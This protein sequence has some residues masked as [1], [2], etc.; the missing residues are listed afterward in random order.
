MS[1]ESSRRVPSGIAAA[2]VLGAAGGAVAWLAATGWSHVVTGYVRLDQLTMLT[3]G[4][5]VGAVTLGGDA[6][7]RRQRVGAPI[8]NGVIVGGVSALAVATVVAL[9]SA[10]GDTGFL[11]QR[12]AGWCAVVTVSSAALASVHGSPI[13][14]AHATVGI[15]LLGGIICGLVA[16]LP[17]AAEFWW[18]IAF[19]V[20]GA[21]IAIAVTGPRLWQAVAIVEHA[22]ARN[23]IPG[24]LALR[25]WAIDDGDVVALGTAQLSCNDGHV[26]LHPPA[27]GATVNGLLKTRG[28]YIPVSC[29]IAVGG[30]RYL[31]QVR[32]NPG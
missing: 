3:L 7:R 31:V 9:L 15:G 12:A 21:T 25:E 5:I 24:L 20:A 32:N 6:L 8:I 14:A 10:T 29:V 26:A 27:G 17:G 4:A 13:R 1:T 22:P 19:T 16:L 11:M 2:A 23:A 28:T 30:Q 18:A